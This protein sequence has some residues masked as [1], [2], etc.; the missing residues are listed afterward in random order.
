MLASNS[1]RS[2]SSFSKSS[3]QNLSNIFFLGSQPH[4]EEREFSVAVRA[5]AKRAGTSLIP[6]LLGSTFNEA[7]YE[8][9][10]KSMEQDRADALLV[11]NEAEH[12]A[13]RATLVRLVAERRLPAMYPNRVFVE[14]GGLMT[15]SNDFVDMFRRLAA[16][17]AD[18]LKGKNPQDIP[19]SQ[20]TKFELVI[21]LKTAKSQGIDV[22]PMLLARAMR[23][24]NRRAIT[25]AIRTWHIAAPDVCDGTSAVGE[26]R[27]RIPRRIRWST[28]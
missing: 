13:Y 1:M 10:F 22:P 5:G 15:Y 27:H 18:I 6:I 16:T 25:A 14:S 8:S 26:S 23:S 21:N 3:C 20:P 12:F 17:I 2:G 24:S 4:W 28:D 11:S 7:A 19:I 9:A